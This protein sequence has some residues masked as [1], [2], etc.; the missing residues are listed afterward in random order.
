MVVQ[1]RADRSVKN[2][3]A[4][5]KDGDVHERSMALFERIRNAY[6][7]QSGL[8]ISV[9]LNTPMPNNMLRTEGYVDASGTALRDDLPWFV[10]RDVVR[11]PHDVRGV[12]PDPA[13]P[14]A[15]ACAY[16]GDAE[17]S[18]RTPNRC[19]LDWGWG[20][21]TSGRCRMPPSEY[22]NFDN[23]FKRFHTCH[24][25][26]LEESLAAQRVYWNN[27]TP[28]QR[29]A[30]YNEIVFKDPEALS[31]P[32]AYFWGHAGPF[33]SPTK[34]DASACAL[35]AE[36]NCSNLRAPKNAGLF[37]FAELWDMDVLIRDI[38]KSDSHGFASCSSDKL[39]RE[40]D[41]AAVCAL[42]CTH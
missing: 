6:H 17:S 42:D 5:K 4:F 24:Y 29:I 18:H 39:I 34:H 35:K 11:A 30:P 8:L 32:A 37:E 1:T 14:P 22:L 9:T 26:R 16:P 38:C 7:S 13:S 12:I 3:R 28:P 40:L 36:Y 2:S 33:R 10:W 31:S 25:D 23:E 20:F 41:P 27:R 15:V 21:N 19:G